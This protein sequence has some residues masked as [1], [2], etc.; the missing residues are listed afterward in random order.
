M[1]NKEPGFVERL[2]T[3]A[4]AKEAQLER[5]RASVP[6]SRAQSKEGQAAQVEAASARKLRTAQRKDADRVGAEQRGAA[7]AAETARQA[8]GVAQE[9]ARKD[10]E[11]DALAEADAALKR[12]QKTARDA[13]YAARK[14]RQK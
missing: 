7:R 11:R 13:K 2:K 14:A 3:A 1:P 6:A 9:R 5:I 8:L 4:K 10:A 12:N